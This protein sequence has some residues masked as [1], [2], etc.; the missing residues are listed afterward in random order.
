MARSGSPVKT[1]DGNVPVRFAAAV[2]KNIVSYL[3]ANARMCDYG[4]TC[5]RFWCSMLSWCS[6]TYGL[7][8]CVYGLLQAAVAVLPASRVVT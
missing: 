7:T 1:A 2:S 3:L 4:T 5:L 8:T 6:A